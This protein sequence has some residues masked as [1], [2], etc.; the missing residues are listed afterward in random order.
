MPFPLG[1]GGTPTSYNLSASNSFTVHASCYGGANAVFVWASNLFYV[2][3]D[4]ETYVSP[5]V[6][7]CSSSF[8][9]GP[10]I[11]FATR[12]WNMTALNSFRVGAAFGAATCLVNHA[13]Q[14]A[15]GNSFTVR[16]IAVNTANMHVSAGNSFQL[17]TAGISGRD[18]HVAAANSLNLTAGP[19]S[20]RFLYKSAGDSF[21]V[22]VSAHTPGPEG[23][24][25]GNSFTLTTMAYARVT[26]PWR[27]VPL[28]MLPGGNLPHS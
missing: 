13:Y 11:T 15:A 12:L 27:K 28:T 19:K 24:T 14:V 26:L 10:T 23:P 8:M 1:G 4:A 16:P 3:G 18:L 17:S 22:H 2:R 6:V 21:T 20:N 9:V 25:A 7:S 5:I